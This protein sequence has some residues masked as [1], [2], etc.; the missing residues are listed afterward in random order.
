[1]KL[2][3]RIFQMA[4]SLAQLKKQIAALERQADAI[5]Q[6]ETKDVVARIKEAI[7]FYDLSAEQLGLGGAKRPGR[8]PGAAK[9]GRKSAATGGKRASKVK[10]RDDAGNSWSGHGRRPKWFLDALASGKTAQD[11]AA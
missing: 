11:M 5:K 6:K 9:S 2:I 10:Y 7:A 4:K 8:K 1:M 3:D